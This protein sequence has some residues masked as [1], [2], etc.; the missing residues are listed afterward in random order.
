MGGSVV[1][2][3]Y[4]RDIYLHAEKVDAVSRHEDV[5]EHMRSV[6]NIQTDASNLERIN[7]W[8]SAK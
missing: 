8:Q 7:R 2:W 1:L 6:M 5:G 3:Y 4:S